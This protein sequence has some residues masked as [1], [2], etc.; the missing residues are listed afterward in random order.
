MSFEKLNNKKKNMEGGLGG[1]K[2]KKK[3]K[4]CKCAQALT[5]KL[6]KLESGLARISRARCGDLIQ[7]SKNV[8]VKRIE[9]IFYFYFYF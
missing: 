1:G 3:K 9:T 2:F 6:C 4:T 5:G 7:G 8:Q